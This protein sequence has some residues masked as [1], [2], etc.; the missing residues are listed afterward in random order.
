MLD[1]GFREDIRNILSRIKTK[2]QT[3]LVSATIDEEIRR[4]SRNYM[5]D[6]VDINVS[7]DKITVDEVEQSFVSVEPY[8]KYRA[9]RLIIKHENPPIVIVFC[10]T[11]AAARKLSKK[12]HQDGIEAK[13][14]H[15]DLIQTKRDRVMERFRKHQIQVLVATDLASRG[16]DVSSISHII[17]YDVPQD[18]QIYVHRI[19][20]TA[21]MGQKGIA[22]S[23]ISS[24]Q[25]KEL[26]NIEMHINREVPQRQVPGFK[27][28]SVPREREPQPVTQPLSRYETPVYS[29]A[30]GAPVSAPRKTLGARFKTKRRRRP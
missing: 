9:I 19:G 27:P 24:E 20:R 21:R 22:I 1:I 28:S 3:I 13:E 5:T 15:G 30:S 2:H 4:L 6:P 17:N 11:K 18:P 25:G 10:N 23:F 29:E 26:T 8:D 12:L 16:I 14:I 7:R